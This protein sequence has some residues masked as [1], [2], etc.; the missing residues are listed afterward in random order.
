MR[1]RGDFH[2]GMQ[3]F[4]R[5]RGRNDSLLLTAADTDRLLARHGAHSEAPPVQHAIAELL[6]IA[7]GPPSYQELAGEVAA[8]AA[9]VLASRR[10]TRSA[11]AGRARVIAAGIAAS[12]VVAFSGAAAA[13]ALPA[14]I[15][16]LAH[17]TF[18]APPPRPSAPL[19]TAT[20]PAGKATPTPGPSS[21]SHQ[22]KAKAPASKAPKAAAAKAPPKAA[23]HAKPKEKARPPGH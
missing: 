3:P 8:V 22:A 16:E 13:N 7:D 10:T 21:T 20:L 11:R 2:S 17:T 18:G 6:D 12:A 15:Q 14:P 5:R 23:A 19:P 9:F 4:S 1:P